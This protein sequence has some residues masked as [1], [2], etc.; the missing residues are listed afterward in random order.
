MINVIICVLSVLTDINKPEDEYSCA[1]NEG[2]T[3]Y[4][5]S[6]TN[7][8]PIKCLIDRWCK[9]GDDVQIEYLCTPQCKKQIPNSNQ[10]TCD[11]FEEKIIEFCDTR[12]ITPYPN[13]IPYDFYN[14]D[15]SLAQVIDH[16]RSDAV[17][18]RIHIDFTGGGRDATALLALSTQIF[19]MQSGRFEMGDIVYANFQDKQI[20]KQNNTFRIVDLMNA[21]SAFTE[22]AKADQ[23]VAFFESTHSNTTPPCKEIHNLCYSLK[24]FADALSLCQIDNIE[25]L[26]Q[27]VQENLRIVAETIP[28]YIKDFSNGMASLDE[29]EDFPDALS[30]K[31]AAALQAKTTT[32]KYTPVEIL[33][34]TLV[35]EIQASF[36]PETETDGELVVETIKWCTKHHLVQQALCIF[37]ENI[38]PC[39]IA[40]G[41]FT[42]TDK[43]E[44]LPEKTRRDLRRELV[45]SA[46]SYPVQLLEKISIG[47]GDF[48]KKYET[49]QFFSINQSRK[50]QLTEALYWVLYLKKKRNMVAHSDSDTK[51]YTHIYKHF[52]KKTSDPLNV[53]EIEEELLTALNF[54]V[55]DEPHWSSTKISYRASSVS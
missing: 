25:L 22:Y 54:I 15:L 19:K 6:Q 7:I 5:G 52:G 4:T 9:T 46:K 21:I 30:M 55:G 13:R 1:F 23:L 38:S 51:S 37:V 36:I 29:L 34:S 53:A 2:Q 35:S 33:F 11:Y 32:S 31:E 47:H 27:K 42:E 3:I 50:S 28:P 43:L 8:A 41:Y 48:K 45:K 26:V 18:K 39:M 16:L 12:G 10:T 49:K 17:S 14:P 20:Y 40:L 44:N 24:E